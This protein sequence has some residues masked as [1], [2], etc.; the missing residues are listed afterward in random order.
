MAIKDLKDGL[1]VMVDNDNEERILHGFR[2]CNQVFEVYEQKVWKLVD[3]HTKIGAL[4]KNLKDLRLPIVCR[5]WVL[6][7][8]WIEEYQKDLLN[9][10]NYFSKR[11]IPLVKD[12][13]A[14]DQIQMKECHT[15]LNHIMNQHSVAMVEPRPKHTYSQVATCLTEDKSDKGQI[16]KPVPYKLPPGFTDGGTQQE[17]KQIPEHDMDTDR[18]NLL[19]D[20]QQRMQ[21]PAATQDWYKS[22]QYGRFPSKHL[23]RP[24]IPTF[25]SQM[26]IPAQQAHQRMLEQQ[27]RQ[28]Q[29]QNHTGTGLR[30]RGRTQQRG[31]PSQRYQ[32]QNGGYY[33]HTEPKR[34]SET[35]H[36]MEINHG[37]KS[38]KVQP[39]IDQQGL[40]EN[41]GPAEDNKVNN[42]NGQTKTVTVQDLKDKYGAPNPFAN[43]VN[44]APKDRRQNGGAQ[45]TPATT[46]Q[47]LD[48]NQNAVQPSN[49]YSDK[50]TNQGGKTNHETDQPNSDFRGQGQDYRQHTQDQGWRKQDNGNW[51]QGYQDQTGYYYNQ[52]GPF[53]DYDQSYRHH[54]QNN[55]SQ[56]QNQKNGYRFAGNYNKYGSTVIPE[57][58]CDM[59]E[60]NTNSVA[61]KPPRW[62]V[63]GTE[64]TRYIQK[65]C[66]N[67][68][69]DWNICFLFEF[70]ERN[71]YDPDAP[72]QKR[73][74][75]RKPPVFNG[76]GDY[77]E[78]KESLHAAF[79]TNK[80]V[81]W[82]TKHQQLLTHLSG[83]AKDCVKF[84]KPRGRAMI[85]QSFEYLDAEYGAPTQRKG[86]M[87]KRL[88]LLKELDHVVIRR[89][90][91]C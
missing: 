2:K 57:Y 28:F 53:E 54:N 74:L 91:F 24:P 71:F 89:Q 48:H 38:N 3:N 33:Q 69:A 6:G 4:G 68:D 29:Q 8:T 56:Q 32:S 25:G 14:K 52:N 70:N 90:Q 27:R 55:Q 60:P 79:I 21:S 77:Q 15:A 1:N 76:T 22:D 51:Q 64:K 86:A 66:C 45:H 16:Q 5:Q 10:I 82:I 83:Q 30:Q 84:L 40:T 36:P 63:V 88:K 65:E 42:T 46:Q 37:S 17:D 39:T 81:N 13:I 49:D 59:L 31:G 7:K 11:R 34:Q 75:H 44:Q 78:W 43:H 58:E 26:T 19:A 67:E 9:K 50:K 73:E 80:A 62:V 61:T 47:N 18:M 12:T 23:S 87:M 85:I 41:K 72:V 35:P 20:W